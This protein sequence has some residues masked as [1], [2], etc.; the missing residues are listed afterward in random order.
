MQKIDND[1]NTKILNKGKIF[2]LASDFSM[3][4]QGSE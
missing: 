4:P 3:A 2:P 1:H